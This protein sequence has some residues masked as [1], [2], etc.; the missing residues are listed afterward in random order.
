M[1]PTQE[2]PTNTTFDE[3]NTSLEPI[4]NTNLSGRVSQ[5]TSQAKS[6][7]MHFGRS[8][9]DNIDRTL[10]SAVGALRSAASSLRSRTAETSRMNGLAHTTTNKLDATAEYFQHHHAREMLS[11]VQHLVCRNPGASLA[12]ALGLGYVIGMSTRRSRRY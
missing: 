7:A 5:A 3:A 1:T 10:V 2:K 4:R 6:T 11:D 9:A 12:V 8:A